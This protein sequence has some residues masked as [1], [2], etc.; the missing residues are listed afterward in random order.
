VREK[1]AM[2]SITGRGG[3]AR[4]RLLDATVDYVA[5]HGVSDLSLRQLAQALGTSHRML[6]HHF[7][8]KEG[9]LVA[10]VRD[11]EARE[12]TYLAELADPALPPLERCERLWRHYADPAQWPHERLFFELYGQALQ[13]RQ[14][15][16][17]LLDGIVESWI[18]P[19]TALH[20]ELGTPPE[21]AAARARLGVAVVRGLLLDLLATGERQAVDAAMAEFFDL[22][23]ASLREADT[24]SQKVGG[25]S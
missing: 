13:G 20:L 15:T 12:R 11:V 22:C 24:R 9:L 1:V 7:G 23:F 17:E 3:E 5:A 19:L 21:R 8:S 4:R 6:I 10:V 2:T 25:M 14:H 18:A 16:G